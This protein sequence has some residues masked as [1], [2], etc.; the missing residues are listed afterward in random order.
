MPLNQQIVRVS[1]LVRNT[2]NHS[3]RA[4]P[5][6]YT[7]L[8]PNQIRKRDRAVDDE[9]WIRAFL[10]TAPY[11][12]LATVNESRPFINSNLF[13]YDEPAHAIYLHTARVGRTAGNIRNGENGLAT[14]FST[15]RMGRILPA[16][17]ALNFSVEYEGVTIFGPATIIDDPEAARAALQLLLDKYAPHL[18]PGRDYRSTTD[19]ELERTAVYRID[20]ESWSGKRNEKP[21]DFPGAF[22]YDPE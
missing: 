2:I 6:D 16:E 14:C 15:F 18:R 21:A 11:G 13:V 4:M 1:L 20:I 5:R 19:E 9:A 22:T 12:V 3:I 8:P 7:Q 17:T 10:H